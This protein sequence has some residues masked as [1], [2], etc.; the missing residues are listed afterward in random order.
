MCKVQKLRLQIQA[1]H[2]DKDIFSLTVTYSGISLGRKLS[3]SAIK[4]DW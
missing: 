2:L 3:E 4:E 1:R